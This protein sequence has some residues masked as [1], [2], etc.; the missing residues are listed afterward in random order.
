M[1]VS[2]EMMKKIP[3]DV[4]ENLKNVQLK[5]RKEIADMYGVSEPTIKRLLSVYGIKSKNI[6]T[7]KIRNIDITKPIVEYTPQTISKVKELENR[8]LEE[9]SILDNVDGIT[10]AHRYHFLKQNL[11]EVPKCICGKCVK[12][13]LEYSD[14]VFSTYCS[15]ECSR[16]NSK[17]TQETIQLLNDKDY[18]YKLRY[19][20]KL[21]IDEIASTIKTTTKSIKQQFIKFNMNIGRQSWID[22]SPEK[23]QEQIQRRIKTRGINE[24]GQ[25][26][27]DKLCDVEYLKSIYDQ[28]L[29]FA[30]IA[31]VLDVNES[32]ISYTFKKYNIPYDPS[33]YF[34]K[35]KSR[36]EEL[37]YQYISS[38]YDG[39][40]IRGYRR[41]YTEFELDIY[42]PELNIG[43]EHNGVFHHSTKLRPK[44]YHKNKR[45]YFSKFGIRVI[46]I[47]SDDWS[48]YTDRV[49]KFLFNFL[50]K[51]STRIGARK[52]N[53]VELTSKEYIDFLEDNHLLGGEYTKV[54][55]GLMYNGKLVSV[56][57]FSRKSPAK[58]FE[59]DKN[60][61]ELTR[62]SN[63]NVNGAFSKLLKYFIKKYRPGS[64]Y[65]LADLD[66]V[67]RNSNVYTKH[68]FEEIS[69]SPPSYGY[70]NRRTKVIE[71]KFNWK[72]KKFAR[73]G[74]DVIGK[75]ESE[76]ANEHSL[77]TCYDSGK[78][79]YRLNTEN[80]Y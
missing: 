77:L 26:K 51:N 16:Q 68:N 12:A 63:T 57:G 80:L 36:G 44:S 30:E 20:D 3:K 71:H 61:W 69:E 17:R 33:R 42:L 74:Y 70:Y 13:D 62:F 39:E 54:R 72:K 5:T 22:K 52:C 21:S 28:G 7:R 11:K 55:L 45:E 43:I 48:V 50:N 64:I 40:I 9:T 58:G 41:A 24:H 59:S 32:V 34:K 25:E 79:K 53:I 18:L 38:I 23:I 47:W 29:I 56:M 10:N 1:A 65:S 15:A 35:G 60:S 27:F 2:E 67:D 75:R 78:I 66:I 73:L 8:L 31:K 46:Q 76:L 6:P 4:L 14:K 19:D 49:K 37:L